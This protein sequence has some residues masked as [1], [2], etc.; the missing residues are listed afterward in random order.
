MKNSVNPKKFLSVGPG[1]IDCGCCFP[2]NRK[3]R[4]IQFRRAKRVAKREAF[5]CEE[6]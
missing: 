3:Q 2:R 1:G 4:K 5:R 6:V